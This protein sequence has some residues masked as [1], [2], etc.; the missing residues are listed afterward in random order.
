MFSPNQ[1]YDYLRYYCHTNKKTSVIRNFT[2]DGSKI[3]MDLTPSQSPYISF[4][5]GFQDINE[6]DIS[7]EKYRLS[8]GCVD[9]YDQEPV[10]I[11]AYYDATIKQMNP[12]AFR[13]KFNIDDFVFSSSMALHNPIICHSE[14]NSNDIENFV[15]NFYIPVHYWTNAITSRYWFSH[16]E[17]LKKDYNDCNK[18]R[19]GVYIRDTSGTRKYRKDIISFIENENLNVFCPSINENITYGSKESASVKWTDHNKFDIQLVPET[20]FDTEKTHLTEKVFKPIIMY[21]PFILFAGSNSLQYMRDYGFKTF[22]DIWDESY[23]TEIDSEKRFDMILQ[24]INNISN[25]SHHEYTKLIERTQSI[26]QYNRNYFYSESFK[27]IIFDELMNGFDEALDIQEDSFYTTPG[28]TLFHYCNLYDRITHK[29]KFKKYITPSLHK[30]LD[31]AISKS[32]SVGDEII[33]KYNHLL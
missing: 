21:Q 11:Q 16:L 1:I 32:S 20:L 19:F 10:D 29:D 23:D 28:G 9:M 33:K 5:S 14:K 18:P 13:M 6:I 15:N 7:N 8:N 12:N 2:N 3:L 4:N 30:A 25:L 26:V 27:N 17:P 24:L 31:Y 22:S